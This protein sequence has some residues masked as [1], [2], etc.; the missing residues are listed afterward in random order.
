MAQLRP[1]PLRARFAHGHIVES[2]RHM[3]VQGE[4]GTSFVPVR[5]G[6]PPEIVHIDIG[7]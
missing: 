7:A 2:G 6:A 4:L 5:L 3:I 1:V